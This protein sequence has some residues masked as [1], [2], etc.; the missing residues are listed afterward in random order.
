MDGFDLHES[1]T[2]HSI[3]QGD[4]LHSVGQGSSGLVLKGSTLYGKPVL[5]RPEVKYPGVGRATM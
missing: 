1:A 5:K 4:E 3:Q 2:D